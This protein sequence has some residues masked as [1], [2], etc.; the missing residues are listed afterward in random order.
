LGTGDYHSDLAVEDE[1]A[2]DIAGDVSD[3]TE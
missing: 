1:A 3:R 2:A